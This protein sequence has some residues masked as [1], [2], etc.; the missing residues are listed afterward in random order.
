MAL[1]IVHY[2]MDK[3]DPASKSEIQKAV[4]L[5]PSLKSK[6]PVL[7][8]ILDGTFGTSTSSYNSSGGGTKNYCYTVLMKKSEGTTTVRTKYAA[9]FIQITAPEGASESSVKNFGRG[10]ANMNTKGY[11]IFQELLQ[12]GMQCTDCKREVNASYPLSEFVINYE[13]MR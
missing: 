8:E 6:F 5:D 11:Q 7:Q 1:G 13:T 12:S 3:T 10:K 9:I 2:T 4:A